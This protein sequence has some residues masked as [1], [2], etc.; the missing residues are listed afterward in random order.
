M[1]VLYTYCVFCVCLVAYFTFATRGFY[2]SFFFT[3]FLFYF[4]R[5]KAIVLTCVRSIRLMLFRL[6]C[7]LL[8]FRPGHASA[9]IPGSWKLNAREAHAERRTR[10]KIKRR[11]SRKHIKGHGRIFNKVKM[12]MRTLQNHTNT[13]TYKISKDT[14]SKNILLTCSQFKSHYHHKFVFSVES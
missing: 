1:H 6:A 13:N 11:S 2:F 10:R 8:H 9:W 5:W 12:R 7:A 14:I 4:I 3:F